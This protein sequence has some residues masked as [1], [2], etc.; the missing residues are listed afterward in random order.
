MTPI[1]DLYSY[2]NFG[3]ND[4]SAMFAMDFTGSLILSLFGL[5]LV[6]YVLQAAGLYALAKRRGI[7]HPWLSWLP[8][9]DSWL[10]GCISD[11][12][13][14]VVKGRNKRKRV[15]LLVLSLLTAALGIWI[16]VGWVQIIMDA[17]MRYQEVISQT[18]M[19]MVLEIIGMMALVLLLWGVSVGLRVVK[20]TA[21]YN[22]YASCVPEDRVVYLLLSIFIN[23]CI[24]LLVFASRKWDLGMPPRKTQLPREEQPPVEENREI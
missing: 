8:I 14:Y 4:F 13:Q 11:Q 5:M 7:R 3:G 20:L 17:A 24:P 18:A 9:G 15:A 6:Q 21:L 16:A 12:Y 23:G 1:E 19:D 2:E 10:L 22:L